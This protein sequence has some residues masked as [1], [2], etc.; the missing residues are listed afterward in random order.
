M[1]PHLHLLVRIAGI[2]A[3]LGL[4]RLGTAVAEP[5]LETEFPGVLA[6]LIGDLTWSLNRSRSR[7]FASSAT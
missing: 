1:S 6:D 3:L 5:A 4:L 2:V 7:S